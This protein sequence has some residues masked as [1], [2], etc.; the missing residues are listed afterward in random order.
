MGGRVLVIAGS[1]CSGGAGLEADQ[2]VLA[3]HGCYAM[4]ATTALTA[5]N[6]TGVKGI[7]VIPAAFVQQQIEACIEDVGV[8]VVKTGML[9][10]AETIDMIARQ[11]AKHRIMSLVVDPVMVSTS[12]AQLLPHEAIRGLC[13]HLLPLTTVLTPNI[14]EAMLILSENGDSALAEYQ[15]CSVSDVESI[16]RR[17]QALGPAWVLVKGGHLPLRAD[18]KVAETEDEKQLVV[19]VL[20]GPEG[21]IFRVQSPYQPSTSTHGTG[22]SLASAIAAGLA[23]GTDVVSA[24]R[25][26]CRYVE[27]GISSAPKLGRGNGPLDHF[28]SIQIL[29]FSP[30]HFLEYLL[31]RLDVKDVWNT[32]IYHPFVMALGDGTLPLESFKGY[33]VQDY[34]YLV[35]FSRA[36]ALAAY[37]SKDIQN[38]GKASEIVSHIIRETQLHVNYC[39]SFDISEQEMQKTEEKQACTA[40]TRYLLDIGQS[41]DWLALQMALA[42]CLLGY[43]AV[44]HMLHSHQ[45]TRRSGNTYWPWIQNYLA[46]DYT[47]AVRLGSE[48]LEKHIRLQS[49]SRIEELVHIFIHATRME[50]GFWEM[51]PY[52]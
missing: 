50:I 10:A 27:A 15:I 37:K 42:P 45:L 5:Q 51:F 14:P 29:P 38:I 25:S 44:A 33:I 35:H 40:Y 21:E 32:F 13:K 2:K 24:V 23:K 28:H 26:A 6:T 4:T 30:G 36:N 12:G 39:K 7:H 8:D 47:K 41:E 49:P 22:C 52:R 3:A 20:V 34:L 46:E 18:M 17:I 9:A 16:G 1:D 48:L 31:Q 19:D 43:G 11:V